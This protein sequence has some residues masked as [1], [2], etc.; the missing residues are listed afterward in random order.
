M[1]TYLYED[2]EVYDFRR[3]FTLLIKNGYFKYELSVD[4]APAPIDEGGYVWDFG[5]FT[6]SRRL[7]NYNFL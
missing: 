4:G 7:Y 5:G 6:T 2:E 3:H 1:A